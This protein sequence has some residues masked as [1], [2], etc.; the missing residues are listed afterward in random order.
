MFQ[1]ACCENVGP[2]SKCANSIVIQVYLCLGP[3]QCALKDVLACRI[4]DIIS[5][6]SFIWFYSLVRTLTARTM[7]ASICGASTATFFNP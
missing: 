5:S 6:S 4:Y 3:L 2:L 7:L 1:I